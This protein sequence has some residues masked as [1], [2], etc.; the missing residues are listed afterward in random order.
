MLLLILGVVASVIQ[1]GPDLKGAEDRGL[2]EADV[3]QLLE[4]VCRSSTLQAG[5]G[6][7]REDMVLLARISCR[8]GDNSTGDG[9]KRTGLGMSRSLVCRAM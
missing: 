2:R 5:C 8:R 1:V 7:P 4:V 3:G 9:D 6:E